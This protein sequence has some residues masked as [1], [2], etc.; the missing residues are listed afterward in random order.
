MTESMAPKRSGYGRYVRTFYVH[1][2]IIMARRQRAILA[3][4]LA[5][6]PVVIPLAMAVVSDS[7]FAENGSQVLVRMT[8]M[9]YLKAI[10]PLLALFF[11]CMLIGEE[12]ETQTMP[13]LLSRPAPRSAMVLGKFLAFVMVSSCILVPSLCLTYAACTLL[14]NLAFDA[15]GLK[16][17]AHY[18]GVLIAALGGYGAFC[19]MLGALTKRPMIVGIALI[20]GWQRLA[21]YS[22]GLVDFFT[23]EKYINILLPKLATE[24]A[25]PVVQAAL[26]E[27]HKKELLIA[28]PQAIFALIVIYV[29]MLGLT[30]LVLRVREY[31]AARAVGN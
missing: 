10:A 8:E 22:P 12:V 14:G 5:L 15:S 4:A 11:A 19:M 7:K 28:L 1:A 6:F 30:T 23:I 3:G 25:K 18:I 29:L 27:F 2:L 26:A 21:L 24:R 17:L 9:L 13:Y 16:L 31:T 20:F